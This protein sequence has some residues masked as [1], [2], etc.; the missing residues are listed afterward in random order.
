MPDA[1]LT[2]QILRAD[3]QIRTRKAVKI[4]T[5]LGKIL[6][7]LPIFREVNITAIET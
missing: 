4:T 3:S 2:T 1:V 6:N 5:L 7:T